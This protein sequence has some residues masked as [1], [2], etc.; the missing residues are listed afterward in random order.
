[1]GLSLRHLRFGRAKPIKVPQKKK[2]ETME[3]QKIY[4]A[5]ECYESI[6]KDGMMKIGIVNR[7]ADNVLAT[8]IPVNGPHTHREGELGHN[9]RL[10]NE[11]KV[12]P[13]FEYILHS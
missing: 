4:R 2:K 3:R 12:L 13:V 11:R 5:S 6:A 8:R 9:D 1:M 7:R 10:V